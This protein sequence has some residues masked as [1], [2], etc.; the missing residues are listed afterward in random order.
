MSVMVFILFLTR[1]IC[2]L[3]LVIGLGILYQKVK[4]PLAL[5]CFMAFLISWLVTVLTMCGGALSLPPGALSAVSRSVIVIQPLCEVIGSILFIL[6][7]MGIAKQAR[8]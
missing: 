3:L 1:P 2:E 8:A 5:F 4:N 7:A 6:V